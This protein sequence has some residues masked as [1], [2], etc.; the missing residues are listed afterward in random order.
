[1]HFNLF[2]RPA[3][4]A[5]P[6]AHAISAVPQ[7]Q[8]TTRAISPLL[9]NLRRDPWTTVLTCVLV[10]AMAVMLAGCGSIAGGAN[11]AASGNLVASVT[12]LAFGN[13]TVGKTATATVSF[14][15]ESAASVQISQIGV[16][17]QYFALASQSSMPVTLAGGA[18][19]TIGVNFDPTAAVAAAGDLTVTSNSSTAN[20]TVPL[21]GTGQTLTENPSGPSTLS[22]VTCSSSTVT[23]AGT[24]SCTVTLT[25]AA[26]SGGATVSLS[27]SD[28]AVTV[29]SSVAV[30]ANA[31]SATFTATATAVTSAQSATLTA[32]LSGSS[33]SFLLDL[34]P[35]QSGGGG[36]PALSVSASSL[37]FGDVT[38]NTQATPQFVTLTSSGS[39][40]LSITSA[41]VTG[42]GFS[43]AGPGLPVS[44]NP[45][46]AITL[47][48]KF[49]PTTAGA[50]TGSISIASDAPGGGVTTI[51]LTGTGDATAAGL[52]GLYCNRATI[53]GAG[54]DLCTVTL[55][56]A[57]P[58]G[59][60][61]VNLASSNT[62][63]TVPSTVTVPA[64]ETSGTFTATIAA[65]T[66]S[67]TANLTAT[68]NGTTK[69]YAL[70]LQA[71]APA[72]SISTNTLNFGDVNLNTATAQSVT[73]TSSGT[74]AV[75]INSATLTGTGFTMTGATFPAT[76]NPGQSATLQVTFDPTTAGAASGSISISTNAP[77]NAT[78]TITLE[79]TGDATP[80]ELGSLT[81]ASATVT[82]A[83]TDICTVTLSAPAS[84]GGVAVVLGSN[85]P[86]VT[87][88][89]NVT[90]VAGTTTA[91]FTARATAVST[92]ED[93]TLAAT[94]SG[95]SKVFAL[96]LNPQTVGLSLSANSLSFG[97]VTIDT[98]ESE[99]VTVTSTGTAPL[100]IS[101]ASL[102]GAG[103][104]MT[105][106][107]V[108]ATLQPGQ[109]AT[110]QVAFD[111]TA[112][113]ADT[114]SI[115]ITSNASANPTADISLSGTGDAAAGALSSLSCANPSIT[116]AGTDDC[117]VT[118]SAAAPTGGTTIT[119]S[120]S[121]T[122]VTVPATVSIAAGSTNAS[123]TATATAVTSA[124][125]A[126]LT[127]T[128]SGESK[129]FSLQLDAEDAILTVSSSN[130]SFGNV[131]V[132]TTDTQ[133]V[134]LTS[135]GTEPLTISSATL[136]GSAFTVTGGTF[137][138]TLNAGQS[139]TLTVKFDPTAAGNVTGSIAVD[140]NATNNGDVT[141]NLSGTG[142][143]AGGA[144][145]LTL[146]SA[147]VAF[148]NVNLNSPSTQTVTLTSSGTSALTISAGTITGTGFTMTG[149][150]FPLT[151]NPGQT[152]TLSLQFDPTTAGA[153]TGTMTL[154]SNSST[155]A[156]TTIALTGTGV[157]GGTYEVA[158]TWDAPAS[159]S[160]AVVSYNVY[161]VTG[162][163]GTYQKLNTSANTPTTYTDSTVA[164]GDTYSYEVTSVDANGIESAPSNIYTATIP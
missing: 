85:N 80:G 147:T 118:L 63:V 19:L 161:R 88:P 37:S 112:A 152:A 21:S 83:A 146:G 25:S 79:G 61:T 106:L 49:D 123:F 30:A 150:T 114:G 132:G 2:V 41:S 23:G 47:E 102:T 9:L 53:S 40:A 15:N 4:T 52:A 43:I 35:Q 92:T 46:G 98:P 76:L 124:E 93:A 128:A 27:S 16:S 10:G 22:S 151:L 74:S 13:V 34:D 159:S 125:T 28:Q 156:T 8:P 130:V 115:L 51:S 138:M 90:V 99:S 7:A 5:R 127:A 120:S 26:Q 97:D 55:S 160:D 108:P 36:T 87:V 6:S 24:D 65:V 105:G 72:L 110:L 12:S 135:S 145:T 66:S 18:S 62:A 54:S 143:A 50:A 122:S 134:T 158:L 68:S 33:V 89:D 155:G 103:F 70:Q 45:G 94:L 69:V 139:V 126:T 73:L 157:Q 14:K 131:T 117:T 20:L 100:T 32:S 77:G 163:T 86:S 136:S 39:A 109:S 60:L 81:C 153:A 133:A 84:T 59:G 57:A 111:P 96:Q 78:V 44:L 148:G 116:G 3:G 119:L 140:S 67:Q 91:T 1:M 17:G 38:I 129:V 71:Q 121:N 58:T 11:E 56:T 104:T 141:I 64:G 48:V 42:A 82:G 101:A 149:I 95:V 154:T 162:T 107:T 31:T 113:G 29:P 164:S 144:A 142:Q 137:P 75:T